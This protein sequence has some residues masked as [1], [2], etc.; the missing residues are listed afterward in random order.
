M[1]DWISA[2][3]FYG[4]DQDRM[5]LT[6]VP[7]LMDSLERRR[8]AD[9]HFFLRYWEAGP[10]LRLRYRST[11]PAATA[12]TEELIRSCVGQYLDRHPSD[13]HLSEQNYAQMAAV[14][15]GMEGRETY[16]RAMSPNDSISFV[17][18]QPDPLVPSAAG[19]LSLHDHYVESSRLAIRVMK[20]SARQRD[21][22]AA[23]CAMTLLA[24]MM[25]ARTDAELACWVE[26][27]AMMAGVDAP[28]P[29]SPV[30]EES[31]EILMREAVQLRGLVRG[32]KPANTDDGVLARWMD[33]LGELAAVVSLTSP[34]GAGG[35]DTRAEQIVSSTLPVLDR[36]AHLACNRMGL[37]IVEEA[38][39]R[40]VAART[41]TRMLDQGS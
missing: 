14:V 31:D 15:A 1:T 6:L 26:R 9:G 33:S 5:I 18:Y 3:V 10:H 20:R 39:V 34:S 2:H 11:N 35:A 19:M 13:R 32:P 29:L 21:R 41:V 8:L 7:R 27:H 25:A 38:H 24:W 4:G 23:G 16:R 30:G 28:R 36:C 12:E 37:S 40:R 22:R 17:P